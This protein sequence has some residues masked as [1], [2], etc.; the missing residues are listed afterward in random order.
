MQLSSDATKLKKNLT[1]KTLKQERRDFA[2]WSQV[3]N[4]EI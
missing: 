2:P 4:L 3:Y 1:M